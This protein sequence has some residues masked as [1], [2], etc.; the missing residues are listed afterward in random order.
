[1]L[2]IFLIL[3]TSFSVIAEHNTH[4]YNHRLPD[5]TVSSITS[6]TSSFNM[7]P[8]AITVSDTDPFYTLIATPLAVHYDEMGTQEIIPLYVKNP[9][10]PSKA[11]E[12][13]E[14][15]IG[16]YADYIISDLFSPEETSLIVAETFWD[17]ASAAVLIENSQAGYEIGINAVPLASYLSIPVIIANEIFG[18]ENKA[19]KTINANINAVIVL[20]VKLLFLLILIF[21]S[22]ILNLIYSN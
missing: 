8:T 1:M 9:I 21:V 15:D 17:S 12:R 5:G 7:V 19:K 18:K 3:T 16:I 2:A 22:Y 6:T 14:H 20:I 11:I 13:A 4:E 10:E